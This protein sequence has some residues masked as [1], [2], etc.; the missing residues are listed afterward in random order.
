MFNW[1]VL[2]IYLN[3]LNAKCYYA[4]ELHINPLKHSGNC[5]P[6]IPEKSVTLYF[7]FMG[8]VWFSL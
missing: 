1:S 8:S 3:H 2:S 4:F 5:M 6:Q 7:V